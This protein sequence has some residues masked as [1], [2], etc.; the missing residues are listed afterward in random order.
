M[1]MEDGRPLN[2][3]DNLQHL[4]VSE[5]K[6]IQKTFSKNFSILLFNVRTSGNIGTIIRSACLMG[7]REVILCGRK[8]YD[9]RHTVGAHNY[10]DVQHWDDVLD[11]TITC[12]KNTSPV[13]YNEKLEYNQEAFYQRLGDRT[14]VILEQGGVDIRNFIWPENPVIVVGNESLGVPDWFA[15]EALRV[16]IPQWS[17]LRS[18]NVAVAAS[19]A[20]WEVSQ[21]IEAQPLVDESTK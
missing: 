18:M 1:N 3:L 14:P 9:R 8:M 4:D 5:L 13:E 19:L 6:E 17:V 21:C 2:V 16:S 20:M 12:I 10:I 7:C 15:P 11:V